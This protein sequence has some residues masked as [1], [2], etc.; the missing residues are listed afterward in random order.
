M[1]KVCRHRR[2]GAS[3]I[4]DNE[5]RKFVSRNNTRKQG[6]EGKERRVTRESL[7]SKASENF[8]MS[9]F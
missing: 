5:T 1:A 9:R 6:G 3:V 7:K 2:N 8:T 4:I